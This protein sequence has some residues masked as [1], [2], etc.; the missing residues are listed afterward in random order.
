MDKFLLWTVPIA[1]TIALALIYFIPRRLVPP[2][3]SSKREEIVAVITA[4]NDIRKT[5]A[6]LLAGASFVI[7]FLLSIYNFNR[8]FT[9]K[10]KQASAEQFAKATALITTKVG[11]S[12]ASAGAFQ[13]LSE[14]A[15][16]DA[17]YHVAVLRTMAQYIAT[18]S[19][20]SCKATPDTDSKYFMPPSIQLVARIL[21][22]DDTSNDY[23][24]KPIN[25]EG[26]CLSRVSWLDPIGTKNIYMP[27]VRLIGADLRNAKLTY[28]NM[29]RAIGGVDQ[30]TDWW[31]QFSSQIKNWSDLDTLQTNLNKWHWANFSNTNLE[32]VHA[33]DA[34]L[35]GALFLEAHL[36]R[37]YWQNA[38]LRFTNF[39]RANL[40]A[41]DMG[42]G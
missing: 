37:S 1:A 9:Q 24:W 2:P 8:D 13:V 31:G 16:Q 30:V 34:R 17:E 23:R 18:T 12:W 20:A 36:E 40:Q 11:D 42:T 39:Y 22:D 3:S 27:G 6:Q 14:V 7:T 4:R 19:Q 33:G 28:S 41:V 21:A 15:R 10:A 35:L 29:D 32:D 5:Y 25:L 38:D 26:A